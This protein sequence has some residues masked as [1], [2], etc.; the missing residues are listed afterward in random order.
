MER[1][2]EVT[3]RRG[4]RL[5]QLLD[6]LKEIKVCCQLKEDLLVRT[7]CRTRFGRVYGPVIRQTGE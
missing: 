5:K 2:M 1:G 7:L 6:D 4:T 3:G